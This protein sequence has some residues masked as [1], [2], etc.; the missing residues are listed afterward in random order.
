V[1]PLQTPSRQL[2]V[3]TLFVIVMSLA[4]LF[5]IVVTATESSGK[6]IDDD[7][8]E[9]V[10]LTVDAYARFAQLMGL[11][12]GAAAFVVTYQ[13]ERRSVLPP[14]AWTFLALGLIC[15]L[16]GLLLSLVGMESVL[17]M[18]A[19]NAVIL[20]APILEASRMVMYG[21][22]VLGACC[23]GVFAVQ[24]I[25]APDAVQTGG[26]ADV[27]ASQSPASPPVMLRGSGATQKG[28]LPRHPDKPD[29]G[30]G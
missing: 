14:T 9:R 26:R 18:I 6:P 5:Y 28:E 29:G 20:D 24:A 8:L 17:R 4:G 11:T 23:V 13:R 2:L 1:K 12:F 16:G 19:H 21:L 7:L 30:V 25:F 10:K 22:L 3:A 27:Q 15:F